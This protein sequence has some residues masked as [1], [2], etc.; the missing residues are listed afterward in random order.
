MPG[1]GLKHQSANSWRTP[2]SSVLD[3]LTRCRLQGTNVLE[4]RFVASR[5]GRDDH[6]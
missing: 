5:R 2:I 6:R 1:Y 3:F 4:A